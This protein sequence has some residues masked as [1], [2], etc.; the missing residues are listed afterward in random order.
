[1]KKYILY[2]GVNG[3]GKSTLY[4]TTNEYDGL[5]RV[6]TDEIVVIHQLTKNI[7]LTKRT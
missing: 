2:A 3:S 1:M 4:Y 5:P 6:N 7:Y